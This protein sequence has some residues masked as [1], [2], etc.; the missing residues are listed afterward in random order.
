MAMNMAMKNK[1]SYCRNGFYNFSQGFNSPRLHHDKTARNISFGRFLMHLS[2]Y[3]H[4]S[5]TI[6]SE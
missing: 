5:A 4:F 3:C 6:N 2:I 1:K